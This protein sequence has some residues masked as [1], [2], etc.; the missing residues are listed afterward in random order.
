MNLHRTLTVSA[1]LA[2]VSLLS[3]CVTPSSSTSAWQSTATSDP[4][5]QQLLNMPVVA[6]YQTSS[7][8]SNIHNQCPGLSKNVSL[9]LELNERR[10]A[11]GRGSFSAIGRRQEILQASR[12][13]RAAYLARNGDLCSAAQRELS[14][15]SSALS[16]LL[17]P[18]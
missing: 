18:S 9:D 7:L 15:G 2:L 8:A 14:E 11:L 1:S 4:R 12:A 17:V 6:F 10:N 5:H 13:H 16:Y 3:A